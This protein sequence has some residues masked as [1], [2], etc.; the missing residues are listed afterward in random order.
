MQTEDIYVLFE[1]EEKEGGD[2]EEQPTKNRLRRVIFEND[3]PP[4]YVLI[5]VIKLMGLSTNV[6]TLAKRLDPLDVSSVEIMTTR[7]K[8]RAI[9][10]TPLGLLQ[11]VL[12]AHNNKSPQIIRFRNW[13]RQHVLE[14]IFLVQ[15]TNKPN[16]NKKQHTNN[17]NEEE[18]EEFALMGIMLTS[19]YDRQ[20]AATFV[21][22]YVHEHP[23]R[24]LQAAVYTA[25]CTSSRKHS[26]SRDIPVFDER[27]LTHNK[28]KR[29][30]L[31]EASSDKENKPP[32]KKNSNNHQNATSSSTKRKPP[33]LPSK[34]KSLS[35]RPTVDDNDQSSSSDDEEKEEE[36][37]N[38]DHNNEDHEH[39]KLVPPRQNKEKRKNAQHAKSH[40]STTHP[41]IIPTTTSD[42]EP[43]PDDEESLSNS[44]QSNPFT[45][46]SSTTVDHL[47]Y[48][49]LLA[50]HLKQVNL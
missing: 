43:L 38:S 8:Q 10:V 32:R 7:G 5:D 1:D 33:A 20:D 44:T 35:R 12:G 37:A 25:C 49:A 3:E 22:E 27:S 17:N 29:K 34:S 2:E 31:E 39:K 6:T 23:E 28:R 50:K 26:S 24:V 42:H 30:H 18:E 40:K 15:T 19:N 9:L 11:C 45:P 13:L 16:T 14:E 41:S 36:E 4:R 21:E 48:N 47:S 46:P